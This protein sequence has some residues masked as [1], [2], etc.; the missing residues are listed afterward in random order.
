MHLK[1]V[2]ELEGRQVSMALLLKV[3]RGYTER[4]IGLNSTK[5]LKKMD[6]GGFA[7]NIKHQV[8]VKKI[9]TAP[10]VKL[11]INNKK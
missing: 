7:L 10:F 9:S 4:Q 1:K 11:Q 2:L 6:I 8:Q 5:L 3:A